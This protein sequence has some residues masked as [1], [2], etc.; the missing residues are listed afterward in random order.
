MEVAPR[1][2]EESGKNCRRAISDESLVLT[3]E[4]EFLRREERECES[5]GKCKKT[6]ERW[7]EKKKSQEDE[8]EVKEKEDEQEIASAQREE[9]EGKGQGHSDSL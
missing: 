1:E 6:G 5:S 4:K 3:G 8:V 9:E 7:R 2:L